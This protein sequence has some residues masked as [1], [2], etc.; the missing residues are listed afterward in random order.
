MVG[1]AVIRVRA[2]TRG[3]VVVLCLAAACGGGNDDTGRVG[4]AA[5]TNEDRAST[6][7]SSDSAPDG[8]DGDIDD[9]E[10]DAASEGRCPLADQR[11]LR[12][13]GQFTGGAAPKS[14]S[15]GAA[16]DVTIEPKSIS[17]TEASDGTVSGEWA[18]LSVGSELTGS[19]DP[20]RRRITGKTV[21]SPFTFEDDL[22][23]VVEMRGFIAELDEELCAFVGR[24]QDPD[25]GTFGGGVLEIPSNPDYIVRIGGRFELRAA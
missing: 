18:H 15:A 1:K 9:S 2:F 25:T 14:G 16:A 17:L 23:R 19:V 10:G 24:F 21:P 8:D 6:T 11:P 20:S 7:S 22:G 12:L 5:G 13:V 3:L 4:D